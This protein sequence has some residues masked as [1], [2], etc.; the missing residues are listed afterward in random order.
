MDKIKIII[1]LAIIVASFV[2]V[3]KNNTSMLDNIM[4]KSK[5]EYE[6]K[7]AIKEQAYKVVDGQADAF[8]TIVSGA[9]AVAKP[10]SDTIKKD[11]K[12]NS[13]DTE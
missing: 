13:K 9:K 5:K 1:G 6:K 10:I 7:Q 8:D 2:Y 3:L 11:D 4:A 12:D